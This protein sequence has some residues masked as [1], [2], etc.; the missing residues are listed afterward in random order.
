MRL[1]QVAKHNTM[2][3]GQSKG[4]CPKKLKSPQ[5]TLK[6]H[7][8]HYDLFNQPG[9]AYSPPSLQPS[10]GY[11]VER[12]LQPTGW[13][14]SIL[15]PGLTTAYLPARTLYQ[16]T[17]WIS[18]ILSPDLATTRLPARTL[19]QPTGPAVFHPSTIVSFLFCLVY[20]FVFYF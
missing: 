3:M 5:I 1:N 18:I 15:S 16:P 8:T 2:M 20:S 12:R 4:K 11:I 7:S 6:T 17:G 19:H 13:T 9:P 10:H 14:N